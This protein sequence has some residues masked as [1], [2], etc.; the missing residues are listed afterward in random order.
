MLGALAINEESVGPYP[1]TVATCLNNLA[2]L[3]QATNRLAG[4]E[5]LHRRAVAIDEQLYAPDHPNVA[6]HLNDLAT[7]LKAT[8][9][10]VE[11]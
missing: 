5:P 7:L 2:Q 3:L 4:A 1:A 6:I 10:V 11:G 8:N 9:R